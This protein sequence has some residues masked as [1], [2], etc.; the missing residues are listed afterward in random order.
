MSQPGLF[1]GDRLAMTAADADAESGTDATPALRDAPHVLYRFFGGD[2]ELLYIGVTVHM[3]IRLTAHERGR[4]QWWTA[5]TRITL[6]HYPNRDSVLAA[7]RAAIK[8]ERP[9][10]N[11]LHNGNPVDVSPNAPWGSSA[12]DMPCDCR[13]ACE[14]IGAQSIYYPWKWDE[15]LAGY[16]CDVGHTWAFSWGHNHSGVAPQWAGR[17]ALRPGGDQ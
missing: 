16:T 8:A 9:R 11:V 17:V 10:W 4:R 12:E 1:E 7:E 2:G 6:E 14:L 5:A 3:G 13:G 15:G